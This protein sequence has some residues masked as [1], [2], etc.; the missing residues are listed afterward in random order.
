MICVSPGERKFMAM[1][2]DTRLTEVWREVR[3]WPVAL[4]VS[5]ATRIL[6]SVEEEQAAPRRESPADL[7][8]VWKTDRPPSDEEVKRILEEEY[9]ASAAVASPDLNCAS[10]RSS[11]A[12][13][14][15]RCA[16]VLAVSAAA[17]ARRIARLS[18]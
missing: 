17:K 10:P 15:S 11:R 18:W 9:D 13:D 6:Q 2:S 4:R 8:G 12:T 14:R 16:S 5:L 7:I 1:Q 3:D